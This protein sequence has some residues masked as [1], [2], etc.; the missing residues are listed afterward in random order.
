MNVLPNKLS[1]SNIN[2]ELQ[3]GVLMNENTVQTIKTQIE[4]FIHY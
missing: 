2:H 4:Q 1:I 3:E